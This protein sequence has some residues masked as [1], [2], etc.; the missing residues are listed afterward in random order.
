MRDLGNF[1]TN[2]D[3]DPSGLIGLVSAAI[4]Q[5]VARREKG[6]RVLKAKLL[7]QMV[8]SVSSPSD[9]PRV[10]L[11]GAFER[12]RVPKEHI[13]DCYIPEAARLLGDRWIAD[14]ATFVEVTQGT[15][16]L[17]ALLHGLQED[18][19]SDARLVP[20]DSSA[21]LVVP[22]GEQHTLG[23]MVLAGQLRRRGVSV[24]VRIAPGLSYL[25]I[26]FAEK[27][28]DAALV[29]LGSAERVDV[30]AKLV[31]TL[32]SVT[33]SELKIAVGGCIIDSVAAPLLEAGADLVTNDLDRVVDTFEL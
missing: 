1:A 5:A 24:C 10:S 9:E 32:K 27:C 6:C 23:A 4:S 17:Q 26:L 16:R 8:S 19:F 14:K 28:F 21:L 13:V 20:G 25:K 29:T 3:A 7:D 18:I 33:T 12:E 11:I 15:A 30:C 22:M 31:K 2:N